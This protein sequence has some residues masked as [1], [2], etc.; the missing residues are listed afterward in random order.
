[1]QCWLIIF[2]VCIVHVATGFTLQ[3]TGKSSATTRRT[4]PLAASFFDTL[5]KPRTSN[6]DIAAQKAKIEALKA[7]LISVSKGTSNGVKASDDQR[8]TITSIVNDLEKLN[9]VKKIS[10]SEKM[11]GNWRLVYT[12]NE[13]SSAG[14]LGP[15]VG[16]VD[17]LITVDEQRYINFVRLG[18][19][20]I[21]GALTATWDNLGDK[22]WRVKFLDIEL[23]AF[24]IPITKKPLGAV[25][26]WR[27]SYLDDDLRILYAAG[28]KNT[29]KENIYILAK[30]A[31]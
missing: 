7:N 30:D 18:N 9:S 19:G 20:I 2:A 28:G 10:S 12:T 14:K 24:G 21:T 11:N 1:M 15:F 5:F 29:V 16:R 27:M 17:Q 3:S 25:G 4:P 6:A 26:T 22:L 8:L 23:K 31:F 13:G